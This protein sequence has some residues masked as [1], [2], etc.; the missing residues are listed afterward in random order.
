MG[1]FS[2]RGGQ[3]DEIFSGRWGDSLTETMQL[4]M[5]IKVL[6]PHI[7]ESLPNEIKKETTLSSRNLV[8]TGLT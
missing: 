4:N 2:G 1:F 3:F 7:W 5:E 8:T 6:G